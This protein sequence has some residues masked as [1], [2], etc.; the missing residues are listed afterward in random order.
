MKKRSQ[1]ITII[2]VSILTVFTLIGSVQADP[3]I[4]NVTRIF[5]QDRIQTSVA[6]AQQGFKGNQL[7]NVIIA[8][9]YSFPDAL[10]ASTLS[11]KLK[12][13]II[14]AG[15]SV[16]D[17]QVSL[18]YIK[19]SLVAGG[20]VTIVGGSAV[21]PIEV[22][23]WL[24]NSGYSVLRLGGE[25]KF[26]TDA[27]IVSKLNVVNGTPVVIA[28]GNDFPDALGIA[29][30]AA[31]KGW[32][33]LLSG[34]NQL[35]DSVKSFLATK[36]P[37]DVYIVG[38]EAILPSTVLDELHKV[39]PNT[40]MTRFGGYDRF[41]TLAQVVTTFYPNPTE[42]YLANG[43]DFADALSGSTNAA[44][45]NAPILLIDPQANTLPPAIREYLVNHHDPNEIIKINVLGGTA[46]VPELA[47]ELVNASIGNSTEPYPVPA[48][49]QSLVEKQSMLDLINQERSK[50]GV[51]SLKFEEKLQKMAQAKADDMVANSYFDHNSSTYGSPFEMMKTFGIGYQS[52]GENLAG[53]VSIQAAHAALMNSPGHKENILRSSFNHVGIGIAIGPQGLIIAQDFI[54]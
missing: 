4:P 10:A 39:S 23:Q 48:S 14:L 3:I 27:L 35:P 50:A 30:I 36:Q 2:S 24:L 12:A 54:D 47:V 22:E 20:T 45:N 28:S 8:S 29:S 31:S 41:D 34:S 15:H 38:G 25:D 21:V 53:N 11:T 44:Q 51:A 42:I 7:Q 46:A 33:I 9:G 13:P 5:G 37:S 1:L 52:A 18:D 40:K 32:P 17:S 26:E 16:L 43:F 19:S 49:V 6:V